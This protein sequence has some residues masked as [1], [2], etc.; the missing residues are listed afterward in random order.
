MHQ[1]SATSRRHGEFSW[2]LGTGAGSVSAARQAFVAWLAELADED[3]LL[4]DM[5]VV[6]SEL[7]SNA[8]ESADH[9]EGGAEVRAE[10]DGDV[11][12]VEVS[13]RVPDGITDIRHWD[14]DDPLR[15]GGRGL[16]IVRAYTDSLVVDSTEG[17]VTVRCSRR[18]TTA[19]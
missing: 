10:V 17:T 15:G 7:A 9:V 19:S 6:V 4:E 3:E 12:N 2:T 5:S 13:N 16:M 18:L 11:V 14:L 1:E 8:I